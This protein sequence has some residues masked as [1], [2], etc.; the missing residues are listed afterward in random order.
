MECQDLQSYYPTLNYNSVEKI[1]EFN[2]KATEVDKKIP[3]LNKK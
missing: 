3:H 2:V 1:K